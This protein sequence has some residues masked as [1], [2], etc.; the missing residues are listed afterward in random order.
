[1]SL[2][3]D[4][5]VRFLTFRF[6]LG[7]SSLLYSKMIDA[8]LRSGWSC[9]PSFMPPL[10]P[11]PSL[12]VP[13]ILLYLRGPQG[14]DFVLIHMFIPSFSGS[15]WNRIDGWERK[16]VSTVSAAMMGLEC[17]TPWEHMVFW[18]RNDST[19][20]SFVLKGQRTMESVYEVWATRLRRALGA[21]AMEGKMNDLVMQCLELW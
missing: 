12:L 18:A 20:K 7:F 9:P 15:T 1:M 2:C 11:F 5:K 4:F 10:S 13:W 14:K 17:W 19:E 3:T 16:C 21:S 6:F 8:L